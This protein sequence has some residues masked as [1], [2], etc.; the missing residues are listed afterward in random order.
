LS[1]QALLEKLVIEP[2]ISSHQF[3]TKHIDSSRE[4]FSMT[5]GKLLCGLKVVCLKGKQITFSQSIQRNLL[6]LMDGFAFYLAYLVDFLVAKVTP[7]HQRLGDL[8]A[9]TLVVKASD[10]EQIASGDVLCL[11]DGIKAVLP[12]CL[13]SAMVRIV[14]VRLVRPPYRIAWVFGQPVEETLDTC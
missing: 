3:V 14:T 11:A 10:T 13:K 5:L 9:K 2:G 8:W 12:G 7:L 6:R 4:L 1:W